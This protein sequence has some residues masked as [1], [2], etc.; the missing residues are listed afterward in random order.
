VVAGEEMHDGGGA[1]AAGGVEGAAG[2]EDAWKA[3]VSIALN[4]SWIGYVV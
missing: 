2:V 3:A 1:E 4:S